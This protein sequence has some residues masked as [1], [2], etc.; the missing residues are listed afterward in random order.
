MGA[1]WD[2]PCDG[3]ALAQ[4]SIVE[5]RMVGLDCDQRHIT[6]QDGSTI[7][8][9][10]CILATGLQDQTRARLGIAPQD[11]VCRRR[12]SPLWHQVVEELDDGDGCLRW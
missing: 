10:V 3:C 8:Y 7:K 4:V 2:R 5:S 6:L 11:Q 1:R 9:E 12:A